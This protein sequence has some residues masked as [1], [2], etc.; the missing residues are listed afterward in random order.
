MRPASTL[1]DHGLAGLR[2]WTTDHD[3]HGNGLKV[4]LGKFAKGV[5]Y[6]TGKFQGD[7][8]VADRLPSETIADRVNGAVRDQTRHAS[9]TAGPPALIAKAKRKLE[10]HVHVLFEVRHGDRQ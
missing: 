5:G 9:F 4:L 2:N 3:H 10:L 6:G 1:G 7:R 8:P